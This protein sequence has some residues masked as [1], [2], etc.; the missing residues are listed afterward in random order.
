MLSFGSFLEVIS[1][2]VGVVSGEGTARPTDVQDKAL[3]LLVSK[4]EDKKSLFPKGHESS[5][6]NLI[7]VL[8]GVACES[9]T[10]LSSR[11]TA[12]NSIKM[13]VEQLTGNHSKKLAKVT[14]IVYATVHA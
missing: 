13:I 9:S 12:L 11:Q 5:I 7:D 14:D 1:Q 10:P 8:M 6:F 3:K 4:L 2:L